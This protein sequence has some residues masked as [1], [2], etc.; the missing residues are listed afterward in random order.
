M[1][2]ADDEDRLAHTQT[3][4]DLQVEMVGRPDSLAGGP[5]R[6]WL[7]G[8]ER[9]TLGTALAEAGVPI[10]PDPRPDQRF[11]FRSDN[12]AFATLGIPAHTLSS[13][14]LHPDY[15]SPDDEVERI[16][17]EHLETVIGVALEAVQV[18]ANGPRLEWNPGGRP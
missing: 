17:F 7:T 14:G 2:A 18:L 15:H 13:F 11:F 1:Q 6:A 4:A 9:S 16:D 5:G 12:I 10:V 8:F 3:V